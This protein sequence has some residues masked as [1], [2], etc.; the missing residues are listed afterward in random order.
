MTLSAQS[1]NA[2]VG[3]V[4]QAGEHMD[5]L[6]EQ[7]QKI[8]GVLQVIGAIVVVADEVRSLRK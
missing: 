1:I 8:D 3:E 7:S 4:D 2:L 6:H 5:S